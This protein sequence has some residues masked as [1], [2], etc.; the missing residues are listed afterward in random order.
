MAVHF[1]EFSGNF[2][3]DSFTDTGCKE[4]I[5]DTAENRPSQ[6]RRRSQKII[7]DCQS[8]VGQ[9]SEKLREV[10]WSQSV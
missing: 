1:V 4:K 10:R 2:Y 9:C 3:R 5:L 8:Y 6:R 7:T